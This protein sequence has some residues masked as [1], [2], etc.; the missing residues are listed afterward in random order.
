MP[1]FVAFVELIDSD[2]VVKPWPTNSDRYGAHPTD[3]QVF[4]LLPLHRKLGSI[5]AYPSTAAKADRSRNL[6][7][8]AMDATKTFETTDG[9]FGVAAPNGDEEAQQNA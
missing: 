8:P 7:A 3:R 4:R 9:L 2:G 1:Q 6:Q 5:R